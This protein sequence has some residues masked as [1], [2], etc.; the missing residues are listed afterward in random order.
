[1]ARLTG[2]QES[3]ILGLGINSG[4][5]RHHG[6]MRRIGAIAL[7]VFATL[8]STALAWQAVDAVGV[9][10]SGDFE[11]TV[12]ATIAPRHPGPDVD[13]TTPNQDAASTSAPSAS[14]PTTGAPPFDA[15]PDDSTTTT[16]PTTD[17]GSVTSQPTDSGGTP[18][19][20]T[21]SSAPPTGTQ[22]PATTSTVPGAPPTTTTST[23]T[24]T[25]PST[26]T[27]TSLPPSTTTQ[28]PVIT[29]TF[30]LAGGTVTVEFSKTSVAA[31][32][33]EPAT[34][35]SSDVRQKSPTEIDVR[36][37]SP[38]HRSR[39]R[40]WWLLGPQSEIQD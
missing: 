24:T 26:T 23:T 16:G 7:W 36:F 8:G 38:G 12:V 9:A 17:N 14:P 6:R 20:S 29:Q 4:W 19:V 34:G 33:T 40:A 35:F 2:R 11:A 39:L 32:V 30:F 22:D 5:V 31:V 1:M 15:S 27:S 18:S 25:V 37:N 3:L 28:T 21:T 13:R 10:A